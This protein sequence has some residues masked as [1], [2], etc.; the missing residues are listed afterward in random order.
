MIGDGKGIDRAALLTALQHRGPD[1]TAH[2][3]PG[4]NVWLGATRLAISDPTDA[5]NQPMASEDGALTV[6]HNGEI[7]NAPALRDRLAARGHKFRSRCDTEVLLYGYREWGDA[8]PRELEGMFA[9][10][11]WDAPRG[12]LFVARD[13]LGVKPLWRAREKDRYVF[14]SEIRAL[15]ACGAVE[16]HLSPAAI[17]SF[18]LAGSVGEPGAIVQ[19][20]EALPP[21]FFERVGRDGRSTTTRYWSLPSEEHDLDLETAART[22]RERLASSVTGCVAA[23]VPVALLL[24]GG[25]DSSALALLA[26][27]HSLTT[28]HIRVG[29]A[30]A[31]RAADLARRLGFDHREITVGENEARA[32]MN[33]GLG[34]Q[35]QPSVD[36]TNTF[37]IARAIHEAGLKV[38]LTGAGADELFLGYPRHKT[39][40]RAR[41]LQGFVP[42][43]PFRK[44]ARAAGSV[45]SLLPVAGL[46][47]VE[48]LFGL[49]AAEGARQTHAAARALFPPAVID[50]LQ[51]GQLP[52]EEP[53]LTGAS[54]AGEVSR[55]DLATYLVD[56]LLRDADVMGMAH[57]VELRVPMLDRKLVEAVV[58]LAAPLKMREGRQK[59][60]LVDA[61][62][63]IPAAVSDGPKEGFE[64]PI[65]SWLAGPLR[66]P[67]EAALR[68][69]IA[70]HRVGLH[71]PSVARVW[72]RFAARPDRPGAHRVWALFALTEWAR[73][74]GASS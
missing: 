16:A 1:R 46:W 29:A 69:P 35:D 64:L 21:G 65:E 28:F 30:A 32:A 26:K 2:A 24:S 15:I 48:K 49:L 9:F 7:Y 19:R 74:H 53:E 63:E 39:Y 45:T 71:S 70:A 57:G 72:E 25:I 14:S 58:T 22:V 51:P 60:L 41:A 61:V 55:L 66:A 52:V 6:V 20:I 5:G 31:G 37:L 33:A 18:L 3:A 17:R 59:P 40:V 34:A 10:A 4:Q 27:G 47:R 38:A 56:T 54:S 73:A 44:I 68:S 12:E 23:D 67:V 8:L 50:R 11:I 42:G 13:P 36:G 43:S 62:P